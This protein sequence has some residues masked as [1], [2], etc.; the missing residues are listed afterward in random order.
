MGARCHAFKLARDLYPVDD[1]RANTPP[2]HR[3]QISPD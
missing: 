3:P 2:K 1:P